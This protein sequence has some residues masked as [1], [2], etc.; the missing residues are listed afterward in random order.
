LRLGW[1]RME[2]GGGG[3]LWLTWHGCGALLCGTWWCERRGPRSQA[4][5]RQAC[6]GPQDVCCTHST[7][8]ALG[9]WIHRAV[10]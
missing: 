3:A 7:P 1:G 5:C 4:P 9:P 8:A 2:R 6:A 10:Q